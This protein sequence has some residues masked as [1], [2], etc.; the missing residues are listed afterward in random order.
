MTSARRLTSYVHAGGSV[1]PAGATHPGSIPD[2]VAALITNPSAWE[3]VADQDPPQPLPAGGVVTGGGAGSDRVPAL[4]TGPE[5]AVPARADTPEAR[6]A[7]A[8][9]PAHDQGGCLLPAVSAVVNDTGKPEPVEPAPRV[10]R[11][12]TRR[13]QGG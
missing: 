1:W 6:D 11:K 5:Y 3:Q 10:K 7:P 8:T 13:N 2:D 12:Y 9:H 4:L